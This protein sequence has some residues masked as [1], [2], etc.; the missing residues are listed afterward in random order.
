MNDPGEP[1]IA[2]LEC[3]ML[4]PGLHNNI[5]KLK[6]MPTMTSL[7]TKIPQHQLRYGQK[8]C[9]YCLLVM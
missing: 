1:K 4:N 5:L 6:N 8:Y 2:V 7:D 9:N 3:F